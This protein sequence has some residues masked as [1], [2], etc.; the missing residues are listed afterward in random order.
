V[1]IV[2]AACSSDGARVDAATEILPAAE[3]PTDLVPVEVGEVIADATDL[4]SDVE[5][6]VSDDSFGAIALLAP[7]LSGFGLETYTTS[8]D[9]FEDPYGACL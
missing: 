7:T 3:P 5:I 4:A 8:C 2:L 6:S 9:P 1:A